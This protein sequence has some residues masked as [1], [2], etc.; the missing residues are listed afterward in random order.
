M[1]LMAE[2]TRDEVLDLAYD[3]LCRRR[4]RTSHNNDV[5]DVRWR[6]A[7]LKPRLRRQLLAGEYRLEPTRRV[8][9]EQDVLEIWSALDALVLKATAIVLS[10]QWHSRLSARCFPSGGSWWG[11]GRRAGRAG[12]IAAIWAT[13]C[14]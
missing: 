12:S 5:W 6:W 13:G 10:R 3:W 7:D 4:Q 2:I 9:C 1:D 11:Q 14:T 8:H